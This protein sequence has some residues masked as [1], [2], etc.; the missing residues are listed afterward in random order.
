VPGWL[1]WRAAD[2]AVGYDAAVLIFAAKARASAP[3]FGSTGTEI[4]HPRPLDDKVKLA[5]VDVF[6]PLQRERPG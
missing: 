4:A 2:T 6:A 3:F 5:V 1:C